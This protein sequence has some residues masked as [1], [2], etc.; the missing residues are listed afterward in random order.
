MWKCGDIVSIICPNVQQTVQLRG[1][2]LKFKGWQ[3]NKICIMQ[4]CFSRIIFGFIC[5]K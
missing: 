5:L 1:K 2:D 3:G 4:T